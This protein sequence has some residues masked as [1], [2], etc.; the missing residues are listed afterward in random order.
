MWYC[1]VCPLPT[2]GKGILPDILKC[3]EVKPRNRE[4]TTTAQII[5][6]VHFLAQLQNTQSMLQA[7]W[8]VL[9]AAT[10]NYHAPSNILSPFPFTLQVLK[11]SRLQHC[12]SFCVSRLCTSIMNVM[13]I[14]TKVVPKLEL[15]SISDTDVNGKLV[16]W[17]GKVFKHFHILGMIIRVFCWWWWWFFYE[18]NF[19]QVF[20][21]QKWEIQAEDPRRS[22]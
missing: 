11:L 4:Q 8:M 7:G 13:E 1:G 19:L 9:V 3:S 20:P 16:I 15:K 21:S 2:L 5:H 17:R 22:L 10:S 14:C 18:T 12:S 6:A